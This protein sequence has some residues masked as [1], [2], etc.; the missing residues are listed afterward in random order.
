MAKNRKTQSA[1]VRFGPGLKSFFLCL[2]IG[3]SGLGYLGQKS[4]L[5]TLADQIRQAE[6]RLEKLRQRNREL[7]QRLEELQSMGELDARVRRMNLGLEAP[8][9]DQIV[10][11]LEQ[12]PGASW[13]ATDRY[14]ADG[15]VQVLVKR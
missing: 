8:Q 14:Y 3:G 15:K 6:V 12:P 11:L 5:Y 13:R 10:K 4:R 7:T 2:L 9:P 1:S